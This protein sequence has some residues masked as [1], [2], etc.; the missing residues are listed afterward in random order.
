M[1]NFD[2]ISDSVARGYLDS[3][4]WVVDK[5]I[6]IEQR[7]FPT[8]QKDKSYLEERPYYD[9]FGKLKKVAVYEFRSNTFIRYT[10][11]YYWQDRLIK[12]RHQINGPGEVFGIAYY[13]FK[14]DKLI[15]SS[16][17]LMKPFTA[18]TVLNRANAYKRRLC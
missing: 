13:V 18:D 9:S 5:S 10:D 3:L 15:D 7:G 6:P 2:D 8:N 1:T 11:F 14:N 12:M 17:V 4:A 16:T